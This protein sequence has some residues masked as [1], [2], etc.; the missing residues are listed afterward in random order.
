MLGIGK[1]FFSQKLRVDYQS[2]FLIRFVQR[3][4]HMKFICFILDEKIEFL[5]TQ[6]AFLRQCLES[7]QFNLTCKVCWQL[8]NLE[9]KPWEFC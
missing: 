1:E 6:Y 2:D 4:N 3:L 8:Q 7:P 5:M 9:R